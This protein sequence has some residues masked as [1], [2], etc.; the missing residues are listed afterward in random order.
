MPTVAE[1]RL[2]LA[3]SSCKARLAIET[4]SIN[5]NSRRAYNNDMAG[6]SKEVMDQLAGA[7]ESVL[8]IGILVGLGAWGGFWLDGK[9]HTTPWLAIVLSILGMCLGLGRMVMKALESEKK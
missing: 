1:K 3:K 2:T 6:M 7:G 9:F 5:E 4:F 8:A